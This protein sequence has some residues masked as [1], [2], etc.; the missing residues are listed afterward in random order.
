MPI[1][2]TTVREIDLSS[3]IEGKRFSEGEH[4]ILERKDGSE[5]RIRFQGNKPLE[6]VYAP[7]GGDYIT[8]NLERAVERTG[9]TPRLASFCVWTVHREKEGEECTMTTKYYY[10]QFQLF[11]EDIEIALICVVEGCGA[12]ED[13]F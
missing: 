5:I 11:G 13:W 6:F 2:E 12:Y 3:L 9:A 8:I 7:A 1:Q 10:K 4:K